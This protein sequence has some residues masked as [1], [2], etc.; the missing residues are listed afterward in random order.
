MKFGFLLCALV[1]CMGASSSF[2][3]K[4]APT[5]YNQ[6][7]VVNYS[8]GGRF[9]MEQVTCSSVKTHCERVAR[10][11]PATGETLAHFQICLINKINGAKQCAVS[12]QNIQ[13]ARAAELIAE[14]QKTTSQD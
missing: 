3:S 12:L 9:M 10:E 7:C 14:A 8:L 1:Y 5:K 4:P 6:S 2:A 11:N 13:C